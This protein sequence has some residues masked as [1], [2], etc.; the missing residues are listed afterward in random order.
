M[1]SDM[2]SDKYRDELYIDKKKVSRYETYLYFRNKDGKLIKY[3]DP[4]RESLT[5]FLERVG[6]SDKD[7]EGHCTSQYFQ[8]F[9]SVMAK[10][11][12]KRIG[13]IGFNAGHSADFFLGY[14]S[15]IQMV[16]FDIMMHHYSHYAKMFIDSKYPGRHTLIAGDSGK[17][18]VTSKKIFDK[19]SPFD[20]IFIDGDH[21]YGPAYN[22]IVNMR[23]YAHPDT[24]VIVDNIAP[25]RGCSRQVYYAYRKAIDNGIVLHKAHYELPGFR[26]AWV[27]CYYNFAYSPH[28]AVPLDTK[29]LERKV[30]VTR[31][32]MQINKVQSPQE[33]VDV[34]KQ[35]GDI[36]RDPT[37]ETDSLLYRAYKI[38]Y[39]ELMEK[40]RKV[41]YRAATILKHAILIDGKLSKEVKTDL[42]RIAK[43]L[44]NV[45]DTFKSPNLSIAM[46]DD[47]HCHLLYHQVAKSMEDNDCKHW[48]KLKDGVEIMDKE[49]T[50]KNCDG[51]YEMKRNI[52]ETY[53]PKLV[54]YSWDET[55]GSKIQNGKKVKVVRPGKI[56]MMYQMAKL[57]NGVKVII[58][59]PHSGISIT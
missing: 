16:S 4:L 5:R 2:D 59:I 58:Q 14:S 9:K 12:I 47:P 42:K 26:D 37:S 38:K 46:Y 49:K 56:R 29:K 48:P 50:K 30:K 45:E 23:Q 27:V 40:M 55:V 41:I 15:D 28:R 35:I 57:R 32:G 34:K 10:R 6:Y 53:K 19:T 17:S 54:T 31:L 52:V 1:L 25:H 24:L 13:E 21:R 51:C 3:A 20:L 43:P 22:D 7:L 36:E 11:K 44:K 18:V 39:D 33:L 8:F